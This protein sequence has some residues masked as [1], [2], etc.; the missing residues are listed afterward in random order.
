MAKIVTKQ[1]KRM[2]ILRDDHIFLVG[3]VRNCAHTSSNSFNI[4]FAISFTH[5]LHFVAHGRPSQK[6]MAS[7]LKSNA[8]ILVQSLTRCVPGIH[9]K[10]VHVVYTHICMYVYY[11]A[12]ADQ[13]HC[14]GVINNI[15][16]PDSAL[17]SLQLSPT[18]SILLSKGV[19][20][21]WVSE[22]I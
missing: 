6:H 21:G 17:Y 4:C 3:A 11:R 16:I 2:A 20:S 15:Y 9:C 22:C 1:R 13:R 19:I 18:G 14:H 8:D 12:C 7:L 10:Y 5:F